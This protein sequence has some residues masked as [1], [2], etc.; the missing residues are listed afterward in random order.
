MTNGSSNEDGARTASQAIHRLLRDEIVSMRRLPGSWINEKEIA[1]DC[2]VSRTPVR[3]ALLRLSD[4]RLV[5]IVPKSGTIVARIPA[6][7]LPDIIMA[8]R[9]LE[10]QTVTMAAEKALGSEIANLRAIVERQ[11]EAEAAGDMAAFHVA[12]EAMHAAIAAT[13]GHATIWSM[14]EQIKVQLDRYRRL[15]LPRPH[16]ISRAIEEHAGIVEAIAAHDPAL[17]GRLMDA[18]LDGLSDLLDK[19]HEMEPDY[20]A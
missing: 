1:A 11:R 10:R 17:A 19:L 15:T 13:A 20:F 9:A 3:E 4:E 2:G 5:E 8:R 18:H 6:A 7:V 12:D 16:R 14:I